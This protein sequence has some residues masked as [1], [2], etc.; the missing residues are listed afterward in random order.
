[1][2]LNDR[3][4]ENLRQTYKFFDLTEWTRRGG[5]PHREPYFDTAETEQGERQRVFIDAALF[6]TWPEW[7]RESDR[8]RDVALLGDAREEN[9]ALFGRS[10][11]LAGEPHFLIEKIYSTWRLWINVLCPDEAAFYEVVE[12]AKQAAAARDA[13]DEEYREMAVLRYDPKIETTKYNSLLNWQDAQ[14]AALLER[15]E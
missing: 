7:K 13:L 1:M 3:R 15:L 9:G 4:G 12:Q 5:V 8:A 6:P 14:A 10:F 2:A 11:P